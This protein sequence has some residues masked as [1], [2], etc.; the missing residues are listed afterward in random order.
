MRMCDV[1][2]YVFMGVCMYEG[3]QTC[4][5]PCMQACMYVRMYTI[6][7]MYVCMHDAGALPDKFVADLRVQIPAKWVAEL[8]DVAD[9]IGTLSHKDR[10][11][12]CR[13]LEDVP[14]M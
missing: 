14:H 12:L 10:D 1:H 4:M 6:H 7:V 9:M 13:S 3:M 8:W 2:M 5:H 11:T